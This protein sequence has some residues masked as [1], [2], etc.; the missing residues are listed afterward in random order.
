MDHLPPPLPRPAE[1]PPGM[2]FTESIAREDH[3]G[4]WRRVA[5]SLIDGIITTVATLPVSI[6]LMT[7]IDDPL[8]ENAVVN[9]VVFALS[10][11]YFAM[12][13][14]GESQA[15]LGK[16]AMSIV[17]T[18]ADGRRIGFG[19][20]TARYFWKLVSG[21]ILGIGYL[22]VAFTRYKQGLHDLGAR[23]LV[24]QSD[25]LPHRMRPGGSG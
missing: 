15:T 9:L 3:A 7:R 6:P 10:W 19:R 22:M 18:D 25:A 21:L 12:M 1:P 8:T 16:R 24:V 14:S 13:E 11:P 20:A 5:A 23:T 17:V 4:F 2:P